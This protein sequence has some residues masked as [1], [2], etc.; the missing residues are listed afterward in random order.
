MGPSPD[1]GD[2]LGKKTKTPQR[3]RKKPSPAVDTPKSKPEV[4]EECANLQTSSKEKKAK[5]VSKP[6]EAIKE[7]DMKKTPKK[8]EAKSFTILKG[9]KSMQ[10]ARKSSKPQKKAPRKLRVAPSE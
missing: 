7:K 8:P 9:G 1:K 3:K 10:A 6:E 4:T 2:N 5:Q